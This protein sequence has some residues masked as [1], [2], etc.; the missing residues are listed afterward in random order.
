MSGNEWIV[1]NMTEARA[2]YKEPFKSGNKLFTSVTLAN[3]VV[4][5]ESIRIIRE[6][7]KVVNRSIP[8]NVNEELIKAER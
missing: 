8:E 1:I 3:K 2:N 5:K 6:S 7:Y 4:L